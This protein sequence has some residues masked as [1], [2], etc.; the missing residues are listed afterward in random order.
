[1]QTLSTERKGLSA[2]LGL[3]QVPVK[4]ASAELQV[5]ALPLLCV[6]TSLNTT[7]V[8]YRVCSKSSP[9]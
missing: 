2:V 3:G 8:P 4:D 5:G 9:P 7:C 6:T 1:M